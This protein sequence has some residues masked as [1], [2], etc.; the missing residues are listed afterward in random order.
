MS[1]WVCKNQDK[2]ADSCFILLRR[3]FRFVAG[4][5]VVAAAITLAIVTPASAASDGAAGPMPYAR[6]AAEWWTWVLETPTSVNPQLDTTG[7]RCGINQE[8]EVWFLA[9][10]F[11]GTFTRTC[12]VPANKMLFFPVVSTFYGAF[13]DDPAGTKSI[14]F[15]RQQVACVAGSTFSATLDG[16]PIPTVHE[17]SIPFVVQLPEDN[18]L[19]ATPDVIK[20]LMLVPSI[21]EGNYV[22][23][24]P[25]PPGSHTIAFENIGGPS[26]SPDLSVTYILTVE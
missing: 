21:D 12:T 6:L 1:T 23:L 2:S 9:A 14:G 15:L 24:A 25:L 17:R 5:S 3:G 26:C 10:S 13:L 20:N 8:G 19:G 7:A 11:G 18:L 16:L 22:L 4:V